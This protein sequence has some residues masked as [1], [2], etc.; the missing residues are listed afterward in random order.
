MNNKEYSWTE[1]LE[2]ANE[3]IDQHYE[4]HGFSSEKYLDDLYREHEMLD[5]WADA[6]S[7][8][9]FLDTHKKTIKNTKNLI[10]SVSMWVGAVNAVDYAA[11]TY[12][13]TL[14]RYDEIEW[15]K[16]EMVL[17]D[18]KLGRAMLLQSLVAYVEP[19]K[20]EDEYD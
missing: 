11:M 3:I 18:P 9:E 2:K 6:K 5:N 19:E 17:D 12:L 13:F 16:L 4:D 7:K 15:K 14:L 10:D 20:E 1:G 8:D